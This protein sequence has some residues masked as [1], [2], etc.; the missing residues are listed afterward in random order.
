D[1]QFLAKEDREVMVALPPVLKERFQRFQVAYHVRLVRKYEHILLGGFHIEEAVYG[2]RF[3]Y[4]GRRAG[5][6]RE[7]EAEMPED[8]LLVLLAAK[9]EVIRRRMREAPHDYAIVPEADIEAVQTQFEE[10]FR[11]SW[12]RHKFRI[13]TSELTPDELLQQ[14]LSA[15]L[16]HLSVRDTLT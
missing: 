12:I 14:F 6:L 16:P 11:A 13:D 7:F 1:R 9:P 8:T 3:Y 10:E 4:P 2:P 15:S 5:E